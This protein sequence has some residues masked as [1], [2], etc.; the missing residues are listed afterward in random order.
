MNLH[1]ILLA[2]TSTA[3]VVLAAAVPASVS[4]AGMP[5]APVVHENFTPL[6]CPHKPRTTVQLEGCAEHRVITIDR[7]IDT[8]NKT[9]FSKLNT[10]GRGEF[11]VT[12]RDWVN[13][14]DTAC[15]SESSIYSGGSLHPLAYANC[16]VS[17][18]SSH[19]K[20]LT[21]MLVAISPGG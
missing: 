8:L 19:V 9:V 4:A 5:T 2:G 18:D 3:A 16:L 14:R 12:N 10:A 13:Y 11:V 6:A 17:L 21:S 7:T 1:R 15:V 20:E